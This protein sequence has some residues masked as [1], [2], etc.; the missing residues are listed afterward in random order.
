LIAGDHAPVIV[1]FDVVGSVNIPPL[2]IAATCVNVGI[3]V[4]LNVK[5]PLPGVL[6]HEGVP[7]VLTVTV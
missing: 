4:E 6:G 2:Q 1:L 3:I 7:V 5:V